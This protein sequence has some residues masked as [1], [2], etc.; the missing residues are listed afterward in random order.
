[1]AHRILR[2]IDSGEE[3]AELPAETSTGAADA[4]RIPVLGA[5]GLLDDSLLPVLVSGVRKYSA[6]LTD[7]AS[8]YEVAHG[9]GTDEVVVFVYW[10]VTG[11]LVFPGVLIPDA[12]R[13]IVRFKMVQPAG[14]YR[15]VVQG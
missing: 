9:L 4:G 7:S 13:V 8:T 3:L 15:V 1:M 11:E 10:K 12:D 2:L 14:E 5:D 6:T